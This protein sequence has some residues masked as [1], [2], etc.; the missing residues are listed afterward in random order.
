MPLSWNEIRDRAM[1]FSQEWADVASE[2]AEAKPFWHTFFDVFG[3]SRRRVATFEE[4][5]KKLDGKDGYIDL[6]WKGILL[7]EHKSR[8]KDLDRAHKQAKDYFPGL[9]ERDLPRYILVSDFE[10]F[11][12]YDLEKSTQHE[13]TLKDLHKNIK[14]FG[15]IAG[16]QTTKF[17]EQ[18]PVN[19]KAAEKMGRLHDALKDIGY[20]GHAL[21]IYLVRILFCLFAED[22]GVF[23][24]RQFQDFIEQRTSDDGSDL[25]P[26]IA[27]LFD[28]LNTPENKRL[29]NLDEQM[30]AFRYV[31]GD[32]FAE[33]LP[34]ASFNSDMRDSL[35]ECC[36]LDW[37]R[38]SPAIFGA[39]F[40]SIMD[41]KLRRN[42]G[43]HYTS[44]KNIMKVIRPLFLDDLREE[45]E[46]C[47]N[48]TRKLEEFHTELSKLKFLDPA[49]GC[50]NFLII[51][52]REIRQLEL[53]I[54]RILFA[55]GEKT[56]RLDISHDI[57][58]NVDQFYGIEI[59][60]FPAQIARTALWLMDHQMNMRVGEE[61]G[62][63]FARL[64]LSKSATI[65]H[66]N[67]LQADWE[68]IVSPQ[69]LSYIFGN[70]PFLGKTYQSDEQR[71][72]MAVVFAGVKNGGLL[73]F[74][75]AWYIKSADYIATNKAIK[76]AFVSTNSITQGEQVG[77]LWPELIR[78]GVKIHF[79][80][81]TFQW[82]NEASGKAAVHCVIIGFALVDSDDKRIFD[83]ADIKGEPLER[84]AKNINPYLA[85]AIDI[86]LEKRSDPLSPNTPAMRYGSKPAD[87][88]FLIL[89][90]EEKADLLKDEPQAE[91]LLKKYIGAE[92]FLYGNYRWCLWL[93]EVKP[94]Q[95]KKLPLVQA[96]IEKVREFRAASTD[97][98]TR[99]WAS[100]PSLFQTNRQPL[101][102]YLA[103]PEVSSENRAYIPIGIEKPTTVASNLLYTVAN[104]TN[105]HFGILSSAMHMAWVRVVAGRLKSDYRYSNGIV[106]NN[107]PW[108]QDITDK[109]KQDIEKAAQD[110]LDSRANHKGASLAD[111][112]GVNTMPPNL[113]KAHR[114]LDATVDA[115][116]SKKKFSGD[117]DRVAFLFDMYQRL[118]APL[119][120]Q[121]QEKPKKKKVK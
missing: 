65:V 50:G 48:S 108:P 70:P 23:E 14:L 45:F 121:K 72:D 104:T 77:I 49:C 56:L 105:F 66:G 102:D 117:S 78:R 19:V 2:D 36:A 21:E 9:K 39:M 71:K 55:K 94:E 15:F 24:R 91:S 22:A 54:L 83:Y 32:L 116:Y 79:A 118:T 20:G 89:E 31:N 60:E 99:E 114:V 1:R 4:R 95:L 51:A 27:E 58:C 3:I 110:V 113:T 96:R 76:A 61:F 38:I 10:R 37:S 53:E 84:K 101:S 97:K 80:H 30:A 111:L 120:A 59:E 44:E 17:E 73:D 29:K 67:A 8:G 103:V 88:G 26:R 43:A 33:R 46:S 40:Q 16:Y 25:A 11:R 112:Y 119:V 115:A 62:Q 57:L 47:R 90:E 69:E 82:S 87:G 52:Y 106:Y 98:N 34:M 100:Y 13:F 75:T 63:Y 86:F 41:K 12:I 92:E 93:N 35:L 5:V 107:F 6:L 85:D 68:E 109:Q 64:P 7:I 28:V 81:K 42:L 18:D 74:V